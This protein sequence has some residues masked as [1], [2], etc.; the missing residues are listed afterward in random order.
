MTSRCLWCGVTE[1]F[2]VQHHHS[3][4]SGTLH[5]MASNPS[6]V[7]GCIPQFSSPLAADATRHNG[8]P[9]FPDCLG[10]I[11]P[12]VLL[13]ATSCSFVANNGRAEVAIFCSH[14]PLRAWLHLV[15]HGVGNF[16]AQIIRRIVM[17]VVRPP[18]AAVRAPR[19]GSLRGR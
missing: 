7:S 17:L 19:Q 8:A 18:L 4:R 14:R 10:A 9:S 12:S 15:R 13:A 5:F 1:I 3:R 11:H 2:A 16:K 6:T